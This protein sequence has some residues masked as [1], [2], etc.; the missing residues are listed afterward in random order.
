MADPA[1]VIRH[2]LGDPGRLLGVVERNVEAKLISPVLELLGWDPARQVLWGPQVQRRTDLGRQAV[3]ADAFVGDIEDER[4]RFIV[5]AKHWAR[6][7]DSKAVDQTLAYLDDVAAHRALL[8]NGGRWLV[9]D[10]GNREPVAAYTV[11]SVGDVDGVVIAL[12]A[13]LSPFLSPTTA[14]VSALPP[15]RVATPAADVDQLA[16]D[17]PLVGELV[18]GIKALAAE[19]AELIYVDEGAKGLL[20]KARRTGRVLAPVNAADPLKPDLYAQEL[21]TLGVSVGTRAVYIAALRRLPAE[22][23]PEAVAGFL[24]ALASVV[25]EL[26]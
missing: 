2:A 12:V 13:A 25:N 7:L 18:A 15:S 16:A 10:A 9:L 8:T 24:T 5:E 23:T 11:T 14:P 22:R 17:E 26:R 4:L 1:A 20:V 6:P 3:E 21:E 19:H